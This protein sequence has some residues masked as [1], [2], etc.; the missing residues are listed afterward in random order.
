MRNTGRCYLV[1]RRHMPEPDPVSYTHLHEINPSDSEK[2]SIP[3][4]KPLANQEFDIVGR[5]LESLPLLVPGEII[6]SG[7]SL[8]SGYL[9]D[10]VRTSESFIMR[11]GVKCYRTGDMGK[12]LENGDI[13]FLGRADQQ[14]KVCL[15]Y[16]SRCV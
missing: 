3:Y 8:A 7:K 13:E 16:T 11:D 2:A 15:L 9:N 6:I 12:Y 4:G 14:I 5:E 10:P 1:A